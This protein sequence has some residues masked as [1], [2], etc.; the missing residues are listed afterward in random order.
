MAAPLFNRAPMDWVAFAFLMVISAANIFLLMYVLPIFEHIYHD[1]LGQNPLPYPTAFVIQWRF[2][3]VSFAF[4]WAAMGI[5]LVRLPS[6]QH[7][8]RFLLALIVAA[9]LQTC[10]SVIILFMPLIVDIQGIQ[11]TR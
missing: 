7:S 5:S 9:V 10:F 4:L 3:F 11:A 1:M 8:M 2:I 6:V